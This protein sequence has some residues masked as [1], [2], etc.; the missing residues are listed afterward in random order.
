MNNV[1][2]FV[3]QDIL[4]LSWLLV[5]CCVFWRFE[6]KSSLLIKNNKNGT[7]R[8]KIPHEIGAYFRV[9]CFAHNLI[10]TRKIKGISCTKTRSR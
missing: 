8:R 5:Y 2:I 7:Y 6:E 4:V 9:L 1:L 10:S 3:G